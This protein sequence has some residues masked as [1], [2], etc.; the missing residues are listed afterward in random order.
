MATAGSAAFFMQE[1]KA[2]NIK[3]KEAQ[4]RY[5]QISEIIGS[6]LKYD[7]AVTKNKLEKVNDKAMAAKIMSIYNQFQA[8]KGINTI[9]Q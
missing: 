6:L 5:L 3:L 4:A 8:Q 9:I 7:L 2:L 1:A